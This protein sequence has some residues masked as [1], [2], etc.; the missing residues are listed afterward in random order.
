MSLSF[1]PRPTRDNVARNIPVIQRL[2]EGAKAPGAAGGCVM[3]A[4]GGPP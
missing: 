2:D 1:H 4:S 3:L